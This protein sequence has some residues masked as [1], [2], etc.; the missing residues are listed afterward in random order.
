[1]ASDSRLLLNDDLARM[2]KEVVVVYLHVVSQNLPGR[3]KEN[4]ENH[5]FM[6]LGLGIEN[7]NLIKKKKRRAE[8]STARQTVVPHT[9][10]GW[11]V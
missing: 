1:M 2:R 9:S 4:N 6:L 3:I 10:N 5:Q 7:R 11:L 8:H